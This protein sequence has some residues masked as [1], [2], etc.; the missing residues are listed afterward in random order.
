MCALI[1]PDVF[2]QDLKTGQVIL[3]D[4]T[5]PTDHHAGVRQAIQTCPCGVITED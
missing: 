2:D 3:L 4:P 1:A 5:P